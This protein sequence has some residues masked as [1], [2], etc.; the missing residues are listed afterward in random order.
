VKAQLK[1]IPVLLTGYVVAVLLATMLWTR[2]FVDGA[3][4]TNLAF[5]LFY[6]CAVLLPVS[7]LSWILHATMIGMAL[8]SMFLRTRPAAIHLS[9]MAVTGLLVGVV[10]RFFF[11]T[12]A[13]QLISF[14]FIAPFACVTLAMGGVARISFTRACVSPASEPVQAPAPRWH[15]VA[16]S[17]GLVCIA[18]LA[19][20]LGYPRYKTRQEWTRT[21][22]LLSPL[23]TNAQFPNVRVQRARDGSVFL[24]G[25]V[26]SVDDL[27]ALNQLVAQAGLPRRPKIVVSI[28]D[29]IAR[30]R[31]RI[32]TKTPQP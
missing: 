5:A 2:G 6:V 25:V 29:H 1:F 19:L 26:Q 3:D 31:T 23:V 9:V 4:V 18:A 16:W 32:S 10:V 24:F 7:W 20:T 12:A 21:D 15:G 27:E 28:D 22:E 14:A 8:L 30:Y 17:I 13:H 11:A